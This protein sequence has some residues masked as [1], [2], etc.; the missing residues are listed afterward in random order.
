MIATT[1][2]RLSTLGLVLPQPIAPLGSYRTVSTIGNVAHVSGL[3][4]F[5]NGTPV[6]GIVGQD[7]SL[8]RAQH[9]A[10]LTML[11]I[12]ACLHE[13][14]GLD[15]VSRCARLTV[16]VR[17]AATF[18]Q[19]PAV[20]DGASDILLDLFGADRLPARSAIGVHTLPMGIPVEIDSV[21]ELHDKAGD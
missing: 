1:T 18:T 19:H 14:C 7:M 5:E 10:R 12:L 3:G 13:Q 8:E 9:C 2:T 16:Y 4:P 17:A 20:A 6:S 15:R 11:M 21:F